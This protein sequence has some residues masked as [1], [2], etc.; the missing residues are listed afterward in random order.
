MN[1]TNGGGFSLSGLL[2]GVAQ[3]GLGYLDRRIDVDMQT[4]L[5]RATNPQVTSDQTPIA[6]TV[7]S[8]MFGMAGGML[9]PLLIVGVAALVLLRK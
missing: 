7:P 6:Q 5:Y 4:R 2:Q 8:Q 3:T 1:E 9:L